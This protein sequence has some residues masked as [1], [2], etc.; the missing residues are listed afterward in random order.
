MIEAAMMM[1]GQSGPMAAWQYV[2]VA[3]SLTSGSADATVSFPAGVQPGDLVVAVMAYGTEGQV[4]KMAE[5]GWLKW[6]NSSNDFVCAAAYREGMA[7][8]RWT[9]SGSV[10]VRLALYAFRANGWSSIRLEHQ[11]GPAVASAV[12]TIVPNTLILN[13]G[14]TPGTTGSW[15]GY[16]T[17]AT[18]TS[19]YR[20]DS[21]PAM[22]LYSANV[23]EP[24]EV[25]N[26]RVNASSGYER[27]FIL[28]AF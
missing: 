25:T 6:G 21:S 1:G 10:R 23:P 26:I 24:K 22:V 16:M 15:S 17:G 14:V 27:N 2:G 12:K 28:T 13:L 9:R 20:S 7:P 8:P 18:Q 5:P 3:T 4:I 19:R 11:N